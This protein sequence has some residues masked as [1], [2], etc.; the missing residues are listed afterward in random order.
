MIVKESRRNL[1]FDFSFD[2]ILDDGSFSLPPSHYDD[3]FSFFDSIDSHTDCTFRHFLHTSKWVC[4]VFSGQSMKIDKP[5]DTLDRGWRFVETDVSRPAD[6]QNLDV[7]ASIWSDFLFITKAKIG[8]VS[9][10]NFTIRDIDIFFGYIDVVEEIEVH[11]VIV[12]LRVL[13][14]DGEVL[15]QVEGHNLFETQSFFFVH[16]DQLFVDAKRSAP[17]GQSNDTNLSLGVLSLY[18]FFDGSGSSE[19]GFCWGGKKPR[20]DF[21]NK[22]EP[23]ELGKIGVSIFDGNLFLKVKHQ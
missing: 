23:G 21:L 8:D 7:D 18:L 2:S 17:C 10:L 20:R 16:P 19:R 22:R 13:F 12:G 15:I 4:C 5:S 14:R 6:S 3:F 9:S 11:V 1:I